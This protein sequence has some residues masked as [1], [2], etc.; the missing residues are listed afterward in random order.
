MI[1][2]YRIGWTKV[3]SVMTKTRSTTRKSQTQSANSYQIAP[4]SKHPPL[5][6]V[7]SRSLQSPSHL[8]NR[9]HAIEPY[10]PP[11]YHGKAQSSLSAT[12]VW[13]PLRTLS[14]RSKSPAFLLTPVR[15]SPFPPSFELRM[16]A[17]SSASSSAF[18]LIS[19]SARRVALSAL[20]CEA[21][22]TIS[23]IASVCARSGS[24]T[25]G[26]VGF[27]SRW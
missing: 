19:N 25:G 3:P 21:V 7:Q 24:P 2:E 15:N 12:S 22:E 20:I 13:R 23:A 8:S 1:L 16:R 26:C 10:P 27:R 14:P 17:F 18:S 4:L 11:K 9:F 6:T 5:Q